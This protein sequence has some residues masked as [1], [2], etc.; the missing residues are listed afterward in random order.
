YHDEEWGLPVLSDDRHMFEMICLEG[1]QAGLSWATI[2]AKRSGYKQAFKDFDVETLVRQASEATSIDELVG[3][4]V[5]G[6][7]D[8]VRSRRKIESVYRNAEAT[9]AVQRE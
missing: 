4:V 3:A 5:E 9:R 7:F 2:L 6:D 1:A 8:V